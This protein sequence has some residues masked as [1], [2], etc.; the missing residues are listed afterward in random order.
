MLLPDEQWLA[1]LKGQQATKQIPVLVVSSVDDP[2]KA[3]A[4]GADDYCLKPVERAWL[5]NRLERV[6]REGRNVPK[7]LSPVVLLIDDQEADRY[8]LKRQVTEGGCAVVEASSGED[9]LR[10]AAELKPD[11]ILLDLNMPGM[12]GF[13]VLEQLNEKPDT[14]SIPVVIVTAQIL[15]PERKPA[16]AHARAIILKHESTTAAWLQVFREIGLLSPLVKA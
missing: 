6:T 12:D 1:E 13:C 15:Q 16:L 5:L 2:R 3:L 4:L 7:G 9:G 11:V 8:I 10:L 14:A